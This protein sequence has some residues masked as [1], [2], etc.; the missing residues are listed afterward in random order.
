MQHRNTVDYEFREIQ[1]KSNSITSNNEIISL[2]LI[3]LSFLPLATLC[4]YV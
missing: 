1:E 4:N 3:C 2:L